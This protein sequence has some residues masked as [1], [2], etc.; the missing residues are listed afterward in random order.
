MRGFNRGWGDGGDSW[1]TTN[2]DWLWLGLI[3]VLGLVLI[4]WLIQAELE[5]R[6]RKL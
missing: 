5:R 1:W 3:G 2:L 6:R 4:F